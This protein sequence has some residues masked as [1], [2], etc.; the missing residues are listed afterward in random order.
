MYGVIALMIVLAAAVIFWP[1]NF[2]TPTV[3]KLETE[4]GDIVLNLYGKVMPRTVA[5]FVRLVEEEF[6][7]DLTFHRV[8]DFVLQGGDPNADGTGGPGWT[9]EFESYRKL[10]HVRGALGMARSP[11]DVNS[12]GSQFY[13]IKTPAHTLDGG[14]AVFGRV[15]EGMDVVD[16]MEVGDK[17]ISATIVSKPQ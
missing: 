3:V 9:I 15:A 12:A 11:L 13:I 7:N 17:I 2:G 16:Q 6:Y 1:P 5:N 14:Y 10:R 4:K 8:E